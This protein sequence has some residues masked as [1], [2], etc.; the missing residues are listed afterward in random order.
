M[1]Y[2]YP[3]DVI[4][5][6]EK[7]VGY[8]ED[9]NNWTIFAKILDDCGYYTPQKKQNVEWCGTFCWCMI[10]TS[11]LPKDRSDVEKKWDALTITYQPTKNNLAAACRYAADYF[12][13]KKAFYP[14]AEAKKGDV[15]FF[16]PAGSETHQ[17]L[18]RYVANNRVYTVE[19][20]KS[21]SVKL[22]DYSLKDSKISGV[23]RPMYDPEPE[24]KKEE[25]KPEETKKEEVKPTETTTTTSK[26]I[27]ELAKE[28]IAGKWGNGKARATALEAAGYDYDEVQNKVNEL[29]GVKKTETKT[30]VK[31][32]VSVDSFLNIR[33]GPGKSYP[34]IWKL[35]NGDE[36]EVLEEKN[37]WTRIAEGQWVSSTYLK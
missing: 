24:V 23:G 7:W 25:T 15:I 6:A 30:V 1:G 22:C 29:L 9:G 10:L 35:Y 28:V 14:V 16:G 32:K 27:D 37:G 17:G 34:S 18:V 8:K 20:N 3:S 5:A 33:T 31:K 12:R 13:S 2:C 21:N 4:S 36:V 11:C 19:G 26:S